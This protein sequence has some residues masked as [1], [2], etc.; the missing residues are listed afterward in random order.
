MFYTKMD[1]N[2]YPDRKYIRLNGFDYTQ[3]Q[4]YFIT[5]V[6]HER[7]QLLSEIINGNLLLN[8]A[9]K[10]ISNVIDEFPNRFP[11]TKIICSIVMPNHIHFV[12]NNEGGH[13]I[14][15][16]IRWF[17]SVTTVKYIHGVKELGWQSFYKTFWQRNYYDH[18]I[19]DQNDYNR[20]VNYIKD[21]PTKWE[22][23]C[24]HT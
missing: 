24:F 6:V 15:E 11:N 18:I 12:I 9:G 3:T 17:K 1:A 4:N 13:Y 2:K 8:A 16:I 22:N 7:M 19:R 21:N 20:I 10:M 23:D 5:I 14:P